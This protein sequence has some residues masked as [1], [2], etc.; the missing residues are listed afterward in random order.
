MDIHLDRALPVGLG[1]QLRAQL[2]ALVNAGALRPGDR[3]PA[4]R[5]LAHAQG[6]NVNTVAAAYADL[7]TEGYLEQRKRAGTRVAAQPPA[8][9]Q[10][11]FVAALAGEAWARARAMGLDA[12]ELVQAMAAHAGLAT[13]PPR[14][15]VALLADD[16]EQAAEIMQRARLLFRPEVDLVASTP[17]E[18]DSQSVHLTALHPA[19]S[20]RLAERASPPPH[21]LDFGTDYP[22]PAD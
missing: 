18:Y 21:Q 7:E 20:A 10:A 3:L 2:R 17:A 14:F 19:L 15:R 8:S 11:A 13:A 22:A 9:P 6:V 16:A 1:D 5:M 12:T 4:A